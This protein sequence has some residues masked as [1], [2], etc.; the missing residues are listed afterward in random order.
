MERSLACDTFRSGPNRSIELFAAIACAGG[1]ATPLM[2]AAAIWA[3]HALLVSYTASASCSP[4]GIRIPAGLVSCTCTR[5]GC[6]RAGP[7]ILRSF[8]SHDC[9]AARIGST[10]LLTPSALSDTAFVHRT[11]FTKLRLLRATIWSRATHSCLWQRIAKA[12]R[13]RARL[14]PAD[15]QLRTHR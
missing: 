13:A 12:A 6:P 7:S 4:R 1:D 11:A 3:G 14:R 2:L 15:T 8:L 10:K 9:Q 5:F